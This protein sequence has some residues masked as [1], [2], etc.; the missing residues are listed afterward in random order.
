MSTLI[1]IVWIVCVVAGIG[2]AFRHSS[3]EWAAADKQRPFWVILLF[4]LGPIA[5]V[6]YLLF[7]RPG[8]SHAQ[9]ISQEFRK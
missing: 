2:D 9:K 8:F 3:A 5:L 1:S 6:P 7:V 4:F